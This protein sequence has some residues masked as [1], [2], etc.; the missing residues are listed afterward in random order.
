[1]VLKKKLISAEKVLT[2]ASAPEYAHRNSLFFCMT[3][4]RALVQKF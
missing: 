3:L 2:T 1:M 4:C